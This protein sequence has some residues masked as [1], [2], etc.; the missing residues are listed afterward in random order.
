MRVINITPLL[1]ESK[2][3][4][5]TDLLWLNQ[6]C[7]VTDVAF[8]LVLHPE[9]KTPTLDKARYLRDCFIDFKKELI[10]SNLHIG[11]L[12]Q[13]TIGHGYALENNPFQKIVRS[14]G[15][16]TGCMCPLDENFQKYVRETAAIVSEGQPDF[17]MVDDD[18]RLVNG[19]MGCFCPLHLDYFHKR[20]GLKYDRET[21]LNILQKTDDASRKIGEQWNECLS[22]SLVMAAQAIRKGIDSVNPDISCGY[23]DCSADI[24]FAKPIAHALQGKKAAFVRINNG[25]YMETTR[26]TSDI[27]QRMYHGAFQVKYLQGIPEILGESDTCPHNR[28]STSSRGLLA[29]IT[30]SLIVGCNGIKL[31]VTRLGSYEPESGK[32][33]REMLKA[34]L[35]FFQ[36][37]SRLV[38]QIEWKGCVSPI[39]TNP[40]S[41]WNPA[42]E[43]KQERIINWGNRVFG[44]MGIPVSYDYNQDQLVALCGDDV[45]ALSDEELKGVLSK[46]VLLDGSA[47]QKV[48]ERG[49]SKYIGVE[50]SSCFDR[51][52]W[53]RERYTDTPFNGDIVNRSFALFTNAKKVVP[54]NDRVQVLS[55]LSCCPWYLSPEAAEVGAGQT[56]FENSLQGRVAVCA[57]VVYERLWENVD[58]LLDEIRKKQ[59]IS[60]FDWL[61][62]KIF[63]GVITSDV[64]AYAQY[65]VIS[66]PGEQA[67]ILYMLNLSIDP[68]K[69]FSV[70]ISSSTVRDILG[71]QENG[72]WKKITWKI[73]ND[74]EILIEKES[75]PLQ[76]VMIKIIR[77]G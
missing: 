55:T 51:I 22:N 12:M 58:S 4:L 25:R 59:F 32:A 49:F 20:T 2:K 34:N 57:E 36:E 73:K 16:E 66:S 40:L 43:F 76:P 18:F 52:M 50:V 13:S 69:E 44:N 63:E 19:R 56:L 47:A 64:H 29:Q 77:N 60:I 26:G 48:C 54:L 31:W 27:P 62:G 67:G 11:I 75:E 35:P 10:N 74:K 37:V 41:N 1:M 8:M 5:V 45:N 28:F 71:L 14:N 39:P 6:N 9:G 24:Q 65:G 3:E 15:T 42:A 38:P 68:I 70:H 46:K 30:G 53:L 17:M 23:C 7:G 61:N 72:H 21:L 33:Y